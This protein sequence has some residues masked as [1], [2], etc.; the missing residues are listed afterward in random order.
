M[1]TATPGNSARR[2]GDVSAVKDHYGRDGI[3]EAITDALV[4]AGIDLDEVTVNHLGPVDEF[5]VGGRSATESLVAR[6]GL[7]DGKRILDVGSGV[8][9]TA[10]YLASNHGHV[11]TGIDLTPEY[12]ETATALTRLVGLDAKAGFEQA[13]VLDLPFPAESFDGAFMLHVGM[14]I[15]D[16]QRAFSEVARVLVDGG[17]F[18]IYDII[19]EATAQLNYPVPWAST[20]EESC[21]ATASEYAVHLEGA[22]FGEIDVVDRS[23]F[24]LD[25]FASLRERTGPPPPIGLHLLMG[26][27]APTRYGNMV[28]AVEAGTIQPM[29]IVARKTTN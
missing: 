27:E 28:K 14:N 25:F 7:P 19:G 8:G 22:G 13:D 29:E 5:H 3:F 21:L 26:S 20:S 18:A 12:V 17:V 1:R 24:A 16:K 2:V 23:R 9:G 6:A 15:A 11:V 10:R 4:V